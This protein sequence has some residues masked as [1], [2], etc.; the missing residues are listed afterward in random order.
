MAQSDPFMSPARGRLAVV[1]ILGVSA[2]V[3]AATMLHV[4][5]TAAARSAQEP[6]ILTARAESAQ[7]AAKIE[8]WNPGFVRRAHVLQLWVSGQR[9]LDAY[10]GAYEALREA[11]AEDVGNAELL[12]LFRRAQA[13]QALATNRKAHLQHGHEGP[14]GTLRPEDIER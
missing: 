8:P 11:Y 14:G 5:A 6:G 2:T 1:V 12:A 7:L 3:L 4:T 10:N 13:V 9:L